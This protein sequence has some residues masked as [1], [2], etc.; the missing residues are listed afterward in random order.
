L[1]G[2]LPVGARWTAAGLGAAGG[3]LG[4]LVLH[5]HCPIADRWHLGLVHGGVVVLAAVL[6]AV[7]VPRV[8]ET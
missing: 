6:A 8:V 2:V 3:S 1:R 5:L 4:G 7:V